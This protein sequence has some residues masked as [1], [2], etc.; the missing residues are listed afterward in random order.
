[1]SI[2]STNNILGVAAN[3]DFQSKYWNKVLINVN[4]RY[5]G[6]DLGNILYVWLF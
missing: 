4:D 5:Y 3:K 2:S 6:W 1:M